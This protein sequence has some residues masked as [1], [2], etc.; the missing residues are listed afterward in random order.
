M[1]KKKKI[2]CFII[3]LFYKDTLDGCSKAVCGKL[4]YK[5]IHFGS[6][7][8]ISSPHRGNR[9]GREAAI[10]FQYRHTG[11]YWCPIALVK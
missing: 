5:V 4:P 1:G 6:S 7:S 8:D 9:G 11:R 10:T 2:A 3:L